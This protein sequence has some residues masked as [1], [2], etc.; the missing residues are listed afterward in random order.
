V[1]TCNDNSFVEF[2]YGLGNLGCRAGSNFLNV[3]QPVGFVA[4]V[5]ALR[6]VG[7][8]EVSVEYKPRLKF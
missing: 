6:G 5:D 2:I 4:G 3:G 7:G 8:V 1:S